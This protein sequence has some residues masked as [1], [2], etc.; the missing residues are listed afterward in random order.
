MSLR[1]FSGEIGLLVFN[2]GG[3]QWRK[4]W[5]FGAAVLIYAEVSAVYPSLLCSI[6]ANVNTM[7]KATTLILLWKWFWPH[8]PSTPQKGF[9][10]HFWCTGYGTRRQMGDGSSL[11]LRFFFLGCLK[12]R[13]RCSAHEESECICISRQ[14]KQSQSL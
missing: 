11:G 10:N 6:R 1:K 4:Q 7:K 9:G 14:R 12:M 8:R 13:L 2:A 5:Q 3:G